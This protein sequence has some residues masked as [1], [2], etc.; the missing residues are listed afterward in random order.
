MLASGGALVSW[1][2]K[3]EKGAELRVRAVQPDGTRQPSIVVGVT[4]AGTT[5]GFPGME[6]TAEAVFFAWTDSGPGKVRTAVLELR[7]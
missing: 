7:N 6:R 2:E 3:A 1:L 4:G 5:S